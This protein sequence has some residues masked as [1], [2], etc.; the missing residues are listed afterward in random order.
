MTRV[1]TKYPSDKKPLDPPISFPLGRFLHPA[2]KSILHYSLSALVDDVEL[3]LRNAAVDDSQCFRCRIRNID[4]S[5]GNV[6]T[7]VVD[8]N[9]HKP[10]GRH[11]CHTQLGTERQRRMRRG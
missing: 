4:D 8:A 9:R 5:P 2:N 3:N 11:V 7:A 10:A 6:W 1:R